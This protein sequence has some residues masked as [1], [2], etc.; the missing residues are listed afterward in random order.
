M[1]RGVERVERLD[2]A[3]RLGPFLRGEVGLQ[4][5]ELLRAGALG[6]EPD[7]AAFEGLEYEGGVGDRVVADQ[8]D[9]RA[10]LRDDGHQAL[11]PQAG[12][13]FADRG[14]ADAEQLGKLVLGEAAAGLELG[15]DDRLAQGRVNLIPSGCP[16]RPLAKRDTHV[17]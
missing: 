7:G 4:G 10:E 11:V 3:A 6:G 9:E 2:V 14:A 12:E 17:A 8:R 16:A 5:L 15:A 1:K 13:R